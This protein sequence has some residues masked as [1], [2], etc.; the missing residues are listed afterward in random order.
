MVS[1]ARLLDTLGGKSVLRERTRTY[2]AI[3]DR[4]RAGLPYAALEAVATRFEIPQEALVRVLALPL[5]TLARRKKERRLRADESDRLLRLSRV[6]ALAE[7][8]LGTREKAAAWLRAPN[9][10]LGGPSPLDCLDTDLGAQKVEQLLHRIEY[11]VY[12]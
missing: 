12:S 2:E 7:E 3:I 4:V 10:V 11:G 6:G 5:R 9:R 1:T 8:I